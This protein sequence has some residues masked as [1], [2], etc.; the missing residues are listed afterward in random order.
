MSSGNGGNKRPASRKNKSCS[1]WWRR[2]VDKRRRNVLVASNSE[3]TRR[4]SRWRRRKHNRR[5]VAG[6]ERQKTTE[7]EGGEGSREMDTATGVTETMGESW[8]DEM[9]RLQAAARAGSSRD[10]EEEYQATESTCWNYWHRKLV[11]ERPE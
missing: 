6:E 10:G 1:G 7:T 2:N 5:W 9:A 4:E 11:C 3:W 8:E